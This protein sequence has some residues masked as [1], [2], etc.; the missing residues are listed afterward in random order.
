[1]RVS[2]QLLQMCKKPPIEDIP[3]DDSGSKTSA[4]PSTLPDSC[5]EVDQCLQK[6]FVT[7]PVEDLNRMKRIKGARA[8][9]TCEWILRTHA[10]CEWLSKKPSEPGQ[11]P[12][13]FLWLQG[14][15]GVGKSTMA[16]FL[17]EELQRVAAASSKSQVAFFFC[18]STHDSHTSATSILRGLLWQLLSAH[19]DL[20]SRFVLPSHRSQG[21]RLFDSFDALWSIFLDVLKDARYGIKYLIVDG[22][23]ECKEDSRTSL[24]QELKIAFRQ[25]GSLERSP[26]ARLLMLSRP[27]PEIQ[28]AF[29]GFRSI[30][31]STSPEVGQDVSLL[32]HEKMTE[33]QLEIPYPSSVAVEVSRI[34]QR[35]AG[36]TFLW[37]GLACAELERHDAKDAV[38]CLERL[39]STLDAL[40]SEL[41]ELACRGSIESTTKIHRMISFAIT[42]AYPLSLL[43][44]AAACGLHTN[45]SG[46]TRESFMQEEIETCRR[47]LVV[48]NGE[49]Y[50]LHESVKDFLI[51][52]SSGYFINE[53]QAHADFAHR[54]IERVY[55]SD[56]DEESSASSRLA[57]SDRIQRSPYHPRWG[58]LK[59]QP[60]SSRG[61]RRILLG[62]SIF[63]WPVHARQARS[64]FVIAQ[65]R[66]LLFVDQS[67]IWKIWSA[68]YCGTA[69]TPVTYLSET[70][71][72]GAFA[73]PSWT[74]L[75]V[76]ASTGVSA[77]IDHAIHS[78]KTS[79]HGRHLA[80]SAVQNHGGAFSQLLS[81]LDGPVFL[82]EVLMTAVLLHCRGDFLHE[83]LLA[84]IDH[85]HVRLQIAPGTLS[86]ATQK[87][88]RAFRLLLDAVESNIVF[89]EVDVQEWTAQR[90]DSDYH[91]EA[92]KLMLSRRVPGFYDSDTF[93]TQLA[94]TGYCGGSTGAAASV[95]DVMR[96]ACNARGQGTVIPEKTWLAA[97]QNAGAGP[98]LLHFF[99]DRGFPMPPLE[100]MLQAAMQSM[101]RGDEI[102]DAILKNSPCDSA[103]TAS[104]EV[105]LQAILRAMRRVNM[106]TVQKLLA[107]SSLPKSVLTQESMLK[108]A[109]SN[110]NWLL[111]SLFTDATLVKANML[112]EDVLLSA[113]ENY[114]FGRQLF[115][116]FLD[117][118]GRDVIFSDRVIRRAALNRYGLLDLLLDRQAFDKS[119]LT[120][121]LYMDI[122]F[123]KYEFGQG[124]FTE[125]LLRRR[126][127]ALPMP[128]VVW[129]AHKLEAE[130]LQTLI[131]WKGTGIIT[132]EIV[133]A[134]VYSQLTRYNQLPKSYKLDV[135]HKHRPDMA[136]ASM[137]M[138]E[139]AFERSKIVNMNDVQQLA[140]KIREIRGG[141]LLKS[142]VE[143]FQTFRQPHAQPLNVTRAPLSPLSQ[144]LYEPMDADAAEKA[145]MRCRLSVGVL[146][147]ATRR[148]DHNDSTIPD[149]EEELMVEE[150][151]TSRPEM[152]SGALFFRP[153]LTSLPRKPV[154]DLNRRRRRRSSG[155]IKPVYIH[156]PKRRVLSAQ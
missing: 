74:V 20:V 61:E 142:E 122:E 119:R 35:K 98:E 92:S 129:I 33:L 93:V 47:L 59:E 154:L 116:I 21:I 62:Y 39:P 99:I 150:Y 94:S 156:L 128:D 77:L 60:L 87:G 29:R 131:D 100:R 134:V 32:I 115:Q 117:M 30:D 17:A 9:G 11:N 124:S 79:V 64:K 48:H 133:A 141:Q 12:H 37:V 7:N 136:L 16:M 56:I 41:L 75:D 5:P 23:D 146:F 78:H 108:A 106:G 103:A 109:A 19:R 46:H 123:N 31:L 152:Y 155:E 70:Q 138:L 42:A 18:N 148:P 127:P 140:G 125:T 80:Y 68:I 1:M 86:L 76:A 55:W 112:T 24:L 54:C 28:R 4:K 118:F 43:E 114:M 89:G 130:E 101:C 44:L 50:L 14:N 132:Q 65:S 102:L 135:I 2:A 71:A 105:N 57:L 82:S 45:Y 90:W 73:F 145:V 85:R 40:Y 13:N 96:V 6:L 25:G 52:E 27:N 34:L 49:V 151:A 36:G 113:V 88:V 58:R 107:F 15:P 10:M 147:S 51:G 91:L 63:Q 53:E 126:D 97:A 149:S 104:T 144:R 111:A 84:L 66:A 26:Y 3:A 83:I 8:E 69:A 67:S 95:L 81:V 139:A 120:Q 121:E 22:L 38:Q 143:A 153:F 110:T 137:D 72:F